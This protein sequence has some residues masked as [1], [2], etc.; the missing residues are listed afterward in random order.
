MFQVSM[1]SGEPVWD[2]IPAAKIINYPLEKAD[3]KPYAQA[4]ICSGQDDIFLQMLSFEVEPSPKS[5]LAAAF[6][7]FPEKYP[8][9]YFFLSTNRAGSL[10]CRFI[11]EESGKSCDI[12]RKVAARVFSGSDLQGIYWCAEFTLPLSLTE[13]YYGELSLSKGS[14][15]SGN[16]Y[17][18][19]DDAERPHYGC[20]YPVDF[21][22]ANPLGSAY[23]GGLRLVDY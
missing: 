1:I 18:L 5:I 8:R 10:N 16:F 15:M 12:A 7:L 20:F 19:C 13:K 21:N 2:S 23:F 4:R 11:D 6:C 9:R 17:K 14:V 3:Y 22:A